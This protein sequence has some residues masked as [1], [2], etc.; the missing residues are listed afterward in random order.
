MKNSA[1][2]SNAC[3]T[4]AQMGSQFDKTL[5]K[6]Y[7]NI[8]QWAITFKEENKRKPKLADFILYFNLRKLP[9]HADKKLFSQTRDSKLELIVLYYLKEHHPQLKITRHYREKLDN[10][11][12]EID[13]Y[14]PEIRMGIEIQ[15]FATHCR[16]ISDAYSKFNNPMKD[17]RYHEE[18]RQLF[19]NIGITVFELWE[20]DIKS[21]EF[22]KI[23]E[24]F[25]AKAE[26]TE[27]SE[28]QQ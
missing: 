21:G 6:D 22:D 20:D 28:I 11:W 14:F 7:R 16:D 4:F 19:E 25:L 24:D 1:F 3:S 23:V 26:Y 12:R 2:C 27:T 15:D 8:N 5:L 13:L 10:R 9:S 17:L 18:K